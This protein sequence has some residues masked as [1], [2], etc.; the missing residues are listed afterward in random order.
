MCSKFG[1][2]RYKVEWVLRTSP[3]LGYFV[4]TAADSLLGVW[5]L[6]LC[7]AKKVTNSSGGVPRFGTLI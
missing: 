3:L 1:E 4:D 6:S 2:G 5:A 7:E